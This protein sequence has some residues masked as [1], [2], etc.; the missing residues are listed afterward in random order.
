MCMIWLDISMQCG[1]GCMLPIRLVGYVCAVLGACWLDI[2]V[3]WSACWMYSSILAC[4]MYSCVIAPHFGCID[5][6]CPVLSISM[7]LCLN[8]FVRLGQL[9]EC[10]VLCYISRLGGF[11]DLDMCTR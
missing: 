1:L 10:I 11:L 6:C 8:V 2:F 3:C 7:Y 9:V 5:A 4:W